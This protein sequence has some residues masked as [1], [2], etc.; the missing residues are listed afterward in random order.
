MVVRKFLSLSSKWFS[1][2]SVNIGRNLWWHD[3]CNMARDRLQCTFCTG[4]FHFKGFWN[5]DKFVNTAANPSSIKWANLTS[6]TKQ[7][8]LR[9]GW[10]KRNLAWAPE[11][12]R[13]SKVRI[14]GENVY[15]P[16]M[17]WRASGS[18]AE[19]LVL[20]DGAWL[21]AVLGRGL[22]L[23]WKQVTG[24]VCW[25]STPMFRSFYMLKD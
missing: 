9:S 22:T 1:E 20:F 12:R 23:F 5:S 11:W 25:I 3:N 19:L 14:P 24:L 2:H 16:G 17:K 13:Q 18:D 21:P 8:G 10:R 6:E 15:A 4:Q 7:I